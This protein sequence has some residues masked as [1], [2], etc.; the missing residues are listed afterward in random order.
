MGAICGLVGTLIIDE[1][2]I[3]DPRSIN[4]RLLLGMKGTLKTR[5]GELF[6]TVAI[7]FVKADDNRIEKDPDRRVV[8]AIALVFSKF[9]ELQTVRQVLVWFRHERVLLPAIVQGR[10][11]RPI[12]MKGAGLSHAASHTEKPRLRRRLCIRTV[13]HARNNRGWAQTHCAHP[14]A[15]SKGLG[16]FDQ[17]TPRRVYLVG[18]V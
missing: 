7:G 2:G 13:R 17:R 5:R 16:C 9:A 1:D 12:E 3:Y 8:D 14:A 4:D 18:S 10:G 6:M 15:R 11:Q